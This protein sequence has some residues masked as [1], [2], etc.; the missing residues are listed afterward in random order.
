MLIV[1]Y[2]IMIKSMRN[3]TINI[4]DVLNISCII[5]HFICFNHDELSDEKCYVVFCFFFFFAF[6]CFASIFCCLSL[7]FSA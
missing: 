2:L 7:F 5:L 3:G 4:F 1:I 6:C